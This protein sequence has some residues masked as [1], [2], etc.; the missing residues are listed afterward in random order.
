MEMDIRI[1]PEY[2]S[3]ELLG[4]G[5]EIFGELTPDNYSRM[6]LHKNGTPELFYDKVLSDKVKNIEGISNKHPAVY[7]VKN[8]VIGLICCMDVNEPTV[9]NSV[10]EGVKLSN[11]KHKVIAISSFMTNDWFG[12]NTLQPYL[13][14]FTVV[15]ANGNTEGVKSF[16]TGQD[17]VKMPV[18]EVNLGGIRLINCG[19]I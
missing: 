16:I 13:H 17:G 4:K 5:I 15:M 11:C 8:V 9:I 2:Y 1:Y 10:K 6:H 12:E 19:L 3:G 18:T 14:G 7:E